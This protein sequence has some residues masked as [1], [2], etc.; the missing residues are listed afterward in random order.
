MDVHTNIPLKN[1]TTMKVGGSTRFMTDVH[2]PEEV[3]LAVTNAQAQ[4]L[5]IYILGGGSNSIA[6]DDVFNGI[7]IRPRIMGITEVE[8]APGYKVF[9]VGAGENWD[10][11]VKM[12]VEQ[13]LSGIEALSAIPG[14]VG[15]APVQNI[16]AYGQDVAETIVSLTAY[17]SQA[18]Q[19][20]VLQNADC[21]F[22]YRDSIFRGS[23]QGRYIIESVTFRLSK[24]PPTPPYYKAVEDYFAKHNISLVTPGELRAAVIAIRTDK[25]P[26]P[27]TTPNAGSFFKNPVV[28]DWQ[29]QELIAAHPDMPSYDM[30]DNKHKIPAGWL[31]EQVGMKGKAIGAIT[32]HEKN[33]VVLKNTGA[34]SYS[35]LAAARDT[36]SGAVRDTF[37]IQLE[38]EPLEIA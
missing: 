14:T 19:H 28:E 21:Q 16:G 9:T 10:N 8:D 12:S 31:I 20:V 24:D 36:I 34:T 26:D 27:T 17:D 15:A 7:V 33:A 4:G 35:D 18:K 22:A 3:E 5:A 25:L 23:E 1:Y 30:P 6:R 13:G 37:R 29:F 11:F 2:T 32:V 38:Q